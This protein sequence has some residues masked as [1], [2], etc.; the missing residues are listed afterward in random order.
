MNWK[1]FAIIVG[2]FQA[3]GIFIVMFYTFTVAY[4]HNNKVI[5]NI[6]HYGEA[7]V[8]WFMLCIVFDVVIIGLWFMLKEL[9]K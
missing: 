9:K 6:N 5:I 2:Y 1:R 4:L 3:A 8:E 7:H